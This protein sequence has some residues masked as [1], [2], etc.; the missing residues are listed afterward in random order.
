MNARPETFAE[1]MVTL[2]LESNRC[3]E[4][5]RDVES[6]LRSLEKTVWSAATAVAA[7]LAILQL[8]LKFL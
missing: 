4:F 1:R 7:V 5:Q 3:K 6:R 2:E 8:L